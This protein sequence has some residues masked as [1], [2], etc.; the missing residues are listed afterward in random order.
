M[1]VWTQ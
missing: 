1:D